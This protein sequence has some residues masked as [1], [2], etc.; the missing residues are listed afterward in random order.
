MYHKKCSLAA[1]TSAVQQSNQKQLNP[2][3][4][5]YP[6][7]PRH[8][9]VK[10]TSCR[11]TVHG[12]IPCVFP[13][14]KSRLLKEEANS[15]LRL[16][17]PTR[18]SQWPVSP[19]YTNR[20]WPANRKINT[21]AWTR[22]SIKKWDKSQSHLPVRTSQFELYFMFAPSYERNVF[23]AWVTLHAFFGQFLI[24][25]GPNATSPRRQNVYV[26]FWDQVYKL[27]VMCI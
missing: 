12:S 21:L 1:F 25:V 14:M 9:C 26:R 2:R 24:R 6:N 3:V 7:I 20:V 16:H 23:L 17:Q 15:K 13:K 27:R 5:Y 11:R 8:T 4:I 18:I 19:S 22:C 10:G